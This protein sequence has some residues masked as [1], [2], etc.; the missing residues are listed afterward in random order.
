MY[1]S[2]I[3][4]SAQ[5]KSIHGTECRF[6]HYGQQ[7]YPYKTTVFSGASTHGR[8]AAEAISQRSVVLVKQVALQNR[9]LR[10]WQKRLFSEE[11]V[12]YSTDDINP[13]LHQVFYVYHS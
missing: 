1:R 5:Q 11:P 13:T 4:S 12:S 10:H 9:S 7:Q 3:D 6:R 2:L 8:Y